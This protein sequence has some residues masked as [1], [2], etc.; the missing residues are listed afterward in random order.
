MRARSKAHLTLLRPARP[1]RKRSLS[2]PA[3]EAR[4]PATHRPAAEPATRTPGRV[5]RD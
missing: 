3:A 4:R 1:A 5:T 2:S